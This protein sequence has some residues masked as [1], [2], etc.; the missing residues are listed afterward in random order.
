MNARTVVLAVLWLAAIWFCGWL[1]F[2]V[3]SVLICA[4]LFFGTMFFFALYDA[5]RTR[6]DRQPR[7]H[8]LRTATRNLIVCGRWPDWTGEQLWNGNE[9]QRVTSSTQS[10]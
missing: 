9:N 2:V 8:G 1:K 7:H 5:I 10:R 6:N 4:G 3:M